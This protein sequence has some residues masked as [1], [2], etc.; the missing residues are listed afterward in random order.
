MEEYQNITEHLNRCIFA[1]VY[2]KSVPD[3]T[4]ITYES[5]MYFARINDVWIHIVKCDV[6]SIASA[7]F[8]S[9]DGNEIRFWKKPK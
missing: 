1:N 8:Y 5:H 6:N 9:I 4:S 3:N 7:N 2:Y